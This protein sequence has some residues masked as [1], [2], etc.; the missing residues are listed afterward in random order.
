MLI[1]KAAKDYFT[2]G[3][4]TK[5]N[6]LSRY[7]DLSSAWNDRYINFSHDYVRTYVAFFQAHRI[8]MIDR[9]EPVAFRFGVAGRCVS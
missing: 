3:Q 1:R 6:F 8:T 9:A 2:W 7:R 5:T 4:W